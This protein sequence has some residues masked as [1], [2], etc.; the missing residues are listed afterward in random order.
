M[1]YMST[2]FC[3]QNN[4]KNWYAAVERTKGVKRNKVRSTFITENKFE[5]NEI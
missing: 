2:C 3:L 4:T 1:M 5:T